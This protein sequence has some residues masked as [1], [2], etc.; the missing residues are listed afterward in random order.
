MLAYLGIAMHWWT[1]SRGDGE[2]ASRWVLEAAMGSVAP[3]QF[4]RLGPG[5]VGAKLALEDVESILE[6]RLSAGY[7]QMTQLHLPKGRKIPPR[8]RAG[9]SGEDGIRR[10]EFHPVLWPPQMS[11]FPSALPPLPSTPKTYRDARDQRPN[12]TP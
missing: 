9:R 12:H 7:P 8:F 3:E 5:Q 11:L 1:R 2:E 10:D 6:H 4:L